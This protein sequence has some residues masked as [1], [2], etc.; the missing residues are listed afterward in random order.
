L[1]AKLNSKTLL[2]KHL[3]VFSAIPSAFSSKVSKKCFKDTNK[4]LGEKN[5]LGYQQMQNFTLDQN[6]LKKS[7]KCQTQIKLET[8]NFHLEK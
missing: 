1:D 7:Q 2:E 6:P 3:A 4:Y 8:K 5:Y